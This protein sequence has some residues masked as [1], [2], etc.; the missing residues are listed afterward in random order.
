MSEAFAHRLEEW[1]GYRKMSQRDLG[2]RL[3]HSGGNAVGAW[4]RGE[5]SPTD[6][7]QGLIFK[8]LDI[9]GKNP[10]QQRVAFWLGPGVQLADFATISVKD[11]N[12]TAGDTVMMPAFLGVPAKGW[13]DP[14]ATKFDPEAVPRLALPRGGNGIVVVVSNDASM[15]CTGVAGRTRFLIDTQ[16]TALKS[17]RTYALTLDKAGMVRNVVLERRHVILQ[18]M[19]RTPYPDVV[20]DKDT[21]NLAI[22]GQVVKME[23]NTK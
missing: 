12:Y 14:K 22:L 1:R 18:S 19:N 6:E 9:P 20:I 2:L 10:Y 4:E 13:E 11:A 23:I 21:A 8:A 17:R 5:A 15:E 3:K 7:T 16:A